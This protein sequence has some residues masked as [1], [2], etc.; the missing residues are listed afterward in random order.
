VITVGKF[1][2]SSSLSGTKPQHFRIAAGK[3]PLKGDVIGPGAVWMRAHIHTRTE[4]PRIH[5]EGSKPRKRK[6]RDRQR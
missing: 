3:T 2:V 1:G 4:K 6:R 5:A